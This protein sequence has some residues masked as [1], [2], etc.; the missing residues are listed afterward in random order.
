[1]I[2]LSDE[3]EVIHATYHEPSISIFIPTEVKI[4]QKN[5]LQHK[6]KTVKDHVKKELSV[7]HTEDVA[8]VVLSKLEDIIRSL[9]Y[10]ELKKSL[11]I[12]VSPILSKVLHLNISLQDKIVVGGYFAIREII[13]SKHIIEKCLF[14][15]LTGK[16]A[17]AYLVVNNDMIK[18]ELNVP[19]N[20]EAYVNDIAERVTNFSDM[21]Y[22]KEV[23]QDKFLLHIDDAMTDILK[24]YPVP[25]FLIGPDRLLGHFNSITANENSIVKTK[26]GNYDEATE[27]ELK[28]LV[29]PLI[30][31]W[32]SE[33]NNKA[34][35]EINDAM[36]KG[37][38]SIGLDAASKAASS[39]LGRLLI[40]E[41][42]FI[43][44]L[45]KK[46]VDTKG[47]IFPSED[48]VDR[49]IK[50][51]ILYGG[52]VVFVNDGMLNNHNHVALVHY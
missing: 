25:V 5:E 10:K 4:S 1:M 43:H 49:L 29:D 18:L 9:S 33:N 19:D 48:L 46:S 41:R 3:L 7:Y 11:A 36:N 32:K 40:L 51:V 45:D 31:E 17:K 28:Q 2:F 26:S 22:R 34:F 27:S 35:L 21:S 16:H 15:F 39:K 23:L 20:S 44:L 12:F 8:R 30:M 13:D 6:L 38:L 50:N 37:K 52:D 42:N 14:L 47:S 24:Q